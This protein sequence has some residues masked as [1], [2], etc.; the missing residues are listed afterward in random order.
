[1]KSEWVREKYRM[2]MWLIFQILVIF[3]K[4]TPQT[5]IPNT[6][7]DA[8]WILTWS[9]MMQSKSSVVTSSTAAGAATTALLKYYGFFQHRGIYCAINI[10]LKNLKAKKI[11]TKPFLL[12]KLSYSFILYWVSQNL[13]QIC[14]VTALKYKFAAYLSRC[15]TDLHYIL[16]HSEF[17]IH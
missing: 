5:W 11:T 17:I 9:Q 15:S 10:F 13:P 14:T 6:P 2:G 4:I 16:G 1:M 8:M 12:K 7:L 3:K